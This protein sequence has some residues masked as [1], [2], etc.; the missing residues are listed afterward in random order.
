MS[1]FSRYI[2]KVVKDIC[3]KCNQGTKL[4]RC[5]AVNIEI[6]AVLLTY[7]WVVRKLSI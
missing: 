6:S 4:K 7:K 2:I 5:G 3:P 1:D